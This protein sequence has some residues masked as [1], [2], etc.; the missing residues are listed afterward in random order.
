MNTKE[1]FYEQNITPLLDQ[2]ME[3]AKQGGINIV[4][5]AHM[6]AEDASG[7]EVVTGCRY[8][9]DE[10]NGESAHIVAISLIG[11][12]PP[13]LALAVI[14]SVENFDEAYKAKQLAREAA[15]NPHGV[16]E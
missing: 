3:L 10:K 2:V 14:R 9:D 13:Q 15:A 11:Q 6:S 16:A 7:K 4:T 1:Q 12:R 5:V 8:Y